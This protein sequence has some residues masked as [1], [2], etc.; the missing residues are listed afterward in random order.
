MTYKALV[1]GLGQIGMGYDMGSAPQSR[2]ATLARAFSEHP[3][4]TL[5]G[6]V[7][8]DE[9]NLELFRKYYHKL[10]YKTIESALEE[11]APDVVAIA[12]PTA[13]HYQVFCET[14]RW[15]SVKA[16]LCEKPLAYDLNHAEDMVQL[17]QT[18]G[19][20][21]YTNYMRRCDKGVVEV[22]RRI[23]SNNIIAPLK[24]S[25]W[26]TKG[27]FNNGS[28]YVNLLQY[29]L[30]QARHLELIGKT[31]TCNVVDPDVDLR[32][33]FDLG[34][35]YFHACN[36]VG[37]AHHS[38]EL[39]AS[40]GRLLYEGGA[41]TWQAAEPDVH[42]AGYT[43]L[44]SSVEQLPTD[45]SRLQWYVADQIARDLAGEV[46]TICTGIEGLSTIKILNQIREIL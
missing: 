42:N 29:W 38:L 30:G 2:V 33:E 20:R 10:A 36:T 43:T 25:C 13:Y 19:I 14:L 8:T 5:V 39:F 31:A 46:V 45:A 34:E 27:I 22:R 15:G 35:V 26:Y 16:I 44:S 32:I 18:A 12:V 4:F 9:A 24:G 21:L 3:L 37:Y 11:T 28:H 6:G 40:N 41:L 1:I 17:A 23:L 7:D